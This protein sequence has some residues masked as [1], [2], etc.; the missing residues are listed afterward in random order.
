MK[1]FIRSETK[2]I[3]GLSQSM[4]LGHKLDCSLIKKKAV[5]RF[6]IINFEKKL[7]LSFKTCFSLTNIQ[8]CIFWIY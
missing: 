5:A 3:I 2:A 8:K 4:A 7:Q 6:L 1:T